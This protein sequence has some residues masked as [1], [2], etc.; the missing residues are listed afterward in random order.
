MKYLA[1]LDCNNFFVS[2][3][4]LFRP[5]LINKPV[6]VLSSNDGCVVARSKEIKDKGIPMGVPYFQIK[7][8]MSEI[9][10]VTFSSHFALYRDIS[11]RV[12]EV[13]R[14]HFPDLEEY[15]IDECFFAFDSDNPESV[16]L[17]LKCEVEKQ[18]GIPVSV[19]VALS[20]TQAK[21]MN[22]VAKRTNGIAVLNANMWNQTVS[23]IRL[24]EIWGVG[25]NRARKF[26]ENGIV[27]VSDLL[28][29]TESDTGRLFGLEGVR[30]RGELKGEKIL[31]LKSQRPPQKS[32]INS[33][34]FSESTTEFMA[35][36]EA[37]KFHLYQG[38]ADLN[39]MQLLATSLRVMIS[40]S[41]YSDFAL[42]GSSKEAS[43]IEPTADLLVLQ[44]VALSLLKEVYQTAI[45]YKKAG[46]ILNGLVSN[47]L[48][49]KSLFTTELGE[50][51]KISSGVSE[52]IIEINRKH[53][54]GLIRLGATAFSQT[55]WQ[56]RRQAVSPAYTTNWTDL[57]IVRT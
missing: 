36:S 4:R 39:Q 11:R 32:I 55:S 13:V 8:I 31:T 17:S 27:V 57:K 15:S 1:L 14:R 34:S 12:F 43:L 49:T 42:Q 40:P 41:R 47:K 45:P 37:I 21:Y 7:D 46:V 52:M 48:Q 29:L 3:E 19:G 23:E 18:I 33:R 35:V 38:V 30:L 54:R 20:K 16:A 44:K 9:G 2:C 56:S 24:S 5:D 10:G 6:V 51:D 28:A 50:Q 26:S 22:T 53:H 25:V